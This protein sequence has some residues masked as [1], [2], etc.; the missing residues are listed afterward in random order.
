MAATVRPR[1]TS[2]DSRRWPVVTHYGF[3]HEATKFKKKSFSALR[4]FRAFVMKKQGRNY[5]KKERG[6]N[7]CASYTAFT[8]FSVSGSGSVVNRRN[9]LT[10]PTISTSPHTRHMVALVITS[11]VSRVR[12]LD[13]W[14]RNEVRTAE[15]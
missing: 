15:Y 1:K 14:G 5:V 13:S 11:P 2:R 4:V 8:N 10:S 6:G 7:I 9:L 12:N 3:Y